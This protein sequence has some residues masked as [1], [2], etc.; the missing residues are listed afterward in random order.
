MQLVKKKKK[1]NNPNQSKNETPAEQEHCAGW[2][3]QQGMSCGVLTRTHNSQAVTN[4]QVHWQQMLLMM[5]IHIF[6]LIFHTR[7]VSI[8]K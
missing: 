4:I 8:C 7:L 6:L 5:P 2:L 1:S 3:W